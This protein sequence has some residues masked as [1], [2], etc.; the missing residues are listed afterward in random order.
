[1]AAPFD[2]L[3]QHPT[4]LTVLAFLSACAEAE[5]GTVRDHCEV[6][7]SVLSKAATAL[8]QAG[9]L[10]VRKGAVGR[11]PRTW[12]VATRAGRRALTEHLAELQ[13]LV[14]AAEAAGAATAATTATAPADTVPPPTDAAPTDVTPAVS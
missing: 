6:S 4:R 8:E 10:K 9:Y 13:R 5:F 3:L 7:D 11:R 14:A 2:P 1:M 12:L